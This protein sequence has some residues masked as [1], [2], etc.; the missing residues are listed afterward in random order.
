MEHI[1]Y[2]FVT[3]NTLTAFDNMNIYA[4]GEVLNYYTPIMRS[5]GKNI[6]V[7]IVIK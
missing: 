3:G 2:T 4:F 1:R 5:S 6:T 7:L